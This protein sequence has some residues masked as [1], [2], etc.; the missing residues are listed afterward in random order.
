MIA[1]RHVDHY[2]RLKPYCSGKMLML[3][4]QDTEVGPPKDFFQCEEYKTL[5]PDRGDFPLDIQED[6]SHMDQ[7]WDTVF[8]LGTLEHVWDAHRAYSN[9]ARMVR[10]GGYFIGHAPVENYNNH[11]IHVTNSKAILDFFNI[12][13]F[14]TI[15]SWKSDSVL[16]WHVAKKITHQTEFERPQQVWTNGSPD[17]SWSRKKS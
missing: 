12:N 2:N 1:S 3:G 9:S 8:N 10:V 13:G 16:L 7:M 4:N 5:D 14:E 17:K 6:L 15:D 11:G